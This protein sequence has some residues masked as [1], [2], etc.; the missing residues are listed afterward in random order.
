VLVRREQV[1]REGKME[2]KP[3]KAWWHYRIQGL[4]PLQVSQP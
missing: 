3:V 2:E 1:K 4:G